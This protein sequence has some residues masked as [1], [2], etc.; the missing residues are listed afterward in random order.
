MEFSFEVTIGSL[1]QIGLDNGEICKLAKLN[2]QKEVY[3]DYLIE[4]SDI[5]VTDRLSIYYFIEDLKNKDLQKDVLQYL[6]NEYKND[7]EVYTIIKV[8]QYYFDIINIEDLVNLDN[9]YIDIILEHSVTNGFY[10]GGLY[11]NEES[12]LKFEGFDGT[13]PT[14]IN[15][16]SIETNNESY[17]EN[18]NDITQLIYK[19]FS[20]YVTCDADDKQPKDMYDENIYNWYTIKEANLVW[21]NKKA[22]INNF[23]NHMLFQKIWKD[24]DY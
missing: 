3:L 1:K 22:A 16:D 11:N 8:I 15:L 24:P 19:R 20:N 6:E 14:A 9:K 2:G 4:E 5:K 18:I 21:E 23:V 10:Y 17:I 13:A 12:F 7:D